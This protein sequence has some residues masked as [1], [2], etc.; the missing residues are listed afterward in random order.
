M[1]ELS[2]ILRRGFD[3]K[4]HFDDIRGKR[5]LIILKVWPSHFTRANSFAQAL[6]QSNVTVIHV[7]FYGFLHN[8]INLNIYYVFIIKKSSWL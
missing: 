4:Q 7:E 1:Q 5:A 8:L 3:P 6:F 2:V